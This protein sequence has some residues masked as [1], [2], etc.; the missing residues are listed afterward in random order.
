MKA[1]VH[2]QL[3][4]DV[5]DPRGFAI[6]GS[7]ESLAFQGVNKVHVGKYFVLDMDDMP[8]EKARV[9]LKAMCEKLLANPVIESY[10]FTIEKD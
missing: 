4:R 6:R 8:E 5:S 9:M 7:L 1:K 2:V 10:D 3:K